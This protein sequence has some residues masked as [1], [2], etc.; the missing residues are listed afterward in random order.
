[1][2]PK[3]HTEL[4][5]GFAKASNRDPIFVKDLMGYYYKEVRKILS[6]LDHPAVFISGLGTFK[7]KEWILDDL[8]AQ[9][10]DILSKFDQ[11]KTKFG[12]LSDIQNVEE[13]I[14]KLKRLK[15][16]INENESRKT[17]IKNERKLNRHLEEESPDI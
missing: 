13:M 3:K 5:E 15:E 8:I 7:I 1:M 4:I 9:H 2:N 17:Q 6:S 16:L 14:T 12:F 11:I 10:E